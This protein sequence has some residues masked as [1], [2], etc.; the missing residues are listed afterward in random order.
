MRCDLCVAAGKGSW[1]T[2]ANVDISADNVQQEL[3]SLRIL[4]VN[5][6]DAETVP[7]DKSQ[8]KWWLSRKSDGG[9]V[10]VAAAAAVA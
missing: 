2:S 7:T 5:G 4:E 6:I 10:D 8:P 3:T 1:C 9:D